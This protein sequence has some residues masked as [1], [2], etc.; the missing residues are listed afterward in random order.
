MKTPTHTYLVRR[1]VDEA[2]ERDVGDVD[3]VVGDVGVDGQ[4][5]VQ[6]AAERLRRASGR[7]GTEGG[8]GLR[9]RRVQRVRNLSHAQHSTSRSARA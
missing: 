7:G 2:E 1:A 4:I 8:R 5:L 3:T 9:V 6:H